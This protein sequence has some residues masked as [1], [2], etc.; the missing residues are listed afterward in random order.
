MADA[1]MPYDGP[2]VT[3]KDAESVGSTLYFTGI[4][5][6]QGH[7]SQRFT[8]NRDCRACNTLRARTKYAADPAKSIAAVKRWVQNNP[9]KA[10]NRTNQWQKENPDRVRALNAA[11]RAKNP[12]KIAQIRRNRR[13][14]KSG[15]GGTH[16]AQDIADLKIVQKNK[17]AYCK[18]S[19][20]KLKMQ[21]D[22]IHP[23]SK[24]GG[25]GRSNLQLLCE[26][27]NRKKRDL[28]PISFAQKI[29]L[30]L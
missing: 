29:G 19:F 27:C 12:D 26:N 30:L 4:P 1:N 23:L 22:H 17:C 11:W 21:V 7:L 15:N 3:I 8:Y 16:T 28:D 25:N 2:I 6:K 24:G 5:C 20:T 13:A 9:E 18:G 10:K 14:R